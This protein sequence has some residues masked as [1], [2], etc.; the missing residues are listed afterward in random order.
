MKKIKKTVFTLLALVAT[1][2]IY[3]QGGKPVLTNK[4]SLITGQKIIVEN[5]VSI[6]SSLS[7][8]MDVSNNTTSENMLEV[9]SGTDKNYTVS[10]TLT[11]MKVNMT[12]MGQATTYDSEKKEDQNTDIGKAF[13][14]K[15]NKPTN[16]IIENNTGTAISPEKKETPKKDAAKGAD[17]MQ[18]LFQALG[19]GGSDESLVEGAFEL[20]PQ[21]KNIGD[22]WSDSTVDAKTKLTHS[23]TLKSITGKEAVIQLNMV[24]DAVNNIEL[25]GMQMDFSSTTKTTG[26][27]LVN[28]ETGLVRKKTTQADISGT[29]Q[30]M[31]QSVPITGKAI[32]TTT[33]Q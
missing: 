5:V 15:L 9:K 22:S 7:P 16:I 10:S 28:I 2:L 19:S 12:M 17:P 26:E 33:Y 3:A 8:G 1:G 14:D 21:G 24:L 20:I 23:Y 27:I 11:K 13:A 32:S 30:L 25:Q 29:I 18:G 4:I 6:E 31:G